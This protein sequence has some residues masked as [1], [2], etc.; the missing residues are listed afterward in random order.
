MKLHIIRS[1]ILRGFPH[2]F[3]YLTINA[4]VPDLKFRFIAP[5]WL[6]I[7]GMVETIHVI[8]YL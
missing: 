3:F 2:H 1:N 8:C 6:R 7:P 5:G 4:V